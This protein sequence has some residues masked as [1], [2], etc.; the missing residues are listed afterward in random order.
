MLDKRGIIRDTRRKGGGGEKILEPPT[1]LWTREVLLDQECSRDIAAK[2]RRDMLR[3]AGYDLSRALHSLSTMVRKI[4]SLELSYLSIALENL[5]QL[6]GLER[7]REG[8]PDEKD[9]GRQGGQA[10]LGK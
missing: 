5:S 10:D 3:D 4:A 1:R 2:S 9:Q 8:K 6:E 7:E